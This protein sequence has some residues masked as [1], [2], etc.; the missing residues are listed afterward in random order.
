MWSQ[1]GISGFNA[2]DTDGNT[3]L[4]VACHRKR[5]VAVEILLQTEMNTIEAPKLSAIY[6]TA[7][8]LPIEIAIR[9]GCDISTLI[10]LLEAN[11]LSQSSS[12]VQR[13][14]KYLRSTK[15]PSYSIEFKRLLSLLQYKVKQSNVHIHLCGAERNGKTSVRNCLTYSL[16]DLYI[17]SM[18]RMIYNTEPLQ[19]PA[20]PSTV[21]MEITTV[22]NGDRR[23][24]FFD[25]GGQD[26]YHVNHDAFLS[27]PES[28]YVVI[29]APLEF[30]LKNLS[31]CA[32]SICLTYER[33]LKFI[34][35]A[36]ISNKIPCITVVNHGDTSSVNC[37]IEKATL[38][39]HLSTVQEKFMDSKLN[40]IGDP[41][42]M[43][44]R[45]PHE[46]RMKLNQHMF[47]C[48]DFIVQAPKIPQMEIIILVEAK[49]QEL[50]RIK[51][52]VL[53]LMEF[54]QFILQ[55]TESTDMSP[56]VYRLSDLV[57]AK[58][59]SSGQVLVVGSWIIIDPNWLT[60][61]VL[62]NIARNIQNNEQRRLKL[63]AED[64][65]ALSATMSGITA[66]SYFEGDVYVLPQV[67]CHIGACIPASM[68]Q[69]S[70]YLVFTRYMPS[71]K[72]CQVVDIRH[73]NHG[74][75]I[76][77]RFKVRSA[78]SNHQSPR[79][80]PPGYFPKLFV[81]IA[82][83]LP[84]FESIEIFDG[85]V[86]VNYSCHDA[87][88]IQ[89]IVRKETCES[90]FLVISS[91][92]TSAYSSHS[93]S[94]SQSQ[95]S[96][97][98]HST[99]WTYYLEIISLLY[100]VENVF[101]ESVVKGVWEYQELALEEECMYLKEHLPRDTKSLFI[102]PYC[103][104][105]DTIT[106]SK[107]ESDLKSCASDSPL[108]NNYRMAMYGINSDFIAQFEECGSPPTSISVDPE[109]ANQ[110]VH[111][112]IKLLIGIRDILANLVKTSHE[113]THV[114]RQHSIMLQTLISNTHSVPTLAVIL[115]VTNQGSIAG[116]I[117]QNRFRL[118]FVCQHTL[119]PAIC[120]PSGD[121]YE[122]SITRD[123]VN[124]AVP[125]LQV[126]R[127]LLKEGL[128][129]MA[130]TVTAFVNSDMVDAAF[131]LLGF[132]ENVMNVAETAKY[133]DLVNQFQTG[134]DVTVN[135]LTKYVNSSAQE[136]RSAYEAIRSF[137]AD[138]DPTLLNLGL[139]FVQSGGRHGWIWP[140]PSVEESFKSTASTG[141]AVSA[142]ALADVQRA[143]SEKA[144]SSEPIM[145]GVRDRWASTVQ[146]TL[147]QTTTSSGIND[148]KVTVW[149]VLHYLHY[150]IVALCSEAFISLSYLLLV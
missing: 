84:K 95:S 1:L 127:V 109:E 63:S 26:E 82:N 88:R 106:L 35:S 36:T 130:N 114:L 116:D 79:T 92:S 8:F 64:V 47:Q 29:L 18:A 80:L 22:E 117:L 39:K 52:L 120:G 136:S 102:V 20:I 149:K 61:D 65:D 44:A 37:S 143:L 133:K 135:D 34:N 128:A 40:F 46:A 147:L 11:N 83:R 21:G 132:P 76:V 25:Y 56:S 71:S 12:V 45:Q 10:L 108:W 137:L 49:L 14:E 43:D 19:L 140:L 103:T 48:A 54:L 107:M 15:S 119:L 78:T 33:W 77:R 2:V 74:R 17:V 50:R 91:A 67:L 134:V 85:A 24:I 121:G 31:D 138:Q 124:K 146:E 55:L 7:G 72:D 16:K 70:W 145:Q 112:D 6:N 41:I 93:P 75:L 42:F 66:S 148:D 4:H 81:A 27:A 129:Q 90:F 5:W 68:D 87:G 28:I 73:P 86:E 144:Q 9:K 110:I 118:V 94:A 57:L 126:G 125:L 101:L 60:R 38:T 51:K 59:T 113:D 115:P 69:N 89:V 142:A 96:K 104:V 53:S 32:G 98:K 58:L 139:Q 150:F 111:M 105:V 141:A 30:N 99:A 100:N 122:I 62:G 97:K 13:I 23:W 123:W 131:T 3:F